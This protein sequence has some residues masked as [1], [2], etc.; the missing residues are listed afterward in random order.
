MRQTAG[1][2]RGCRVE[3]FL[4][5]LQNGIMVFAA[6]HIEAAKRCGQRSI[7]VRKQQQAPRK[8]LVASDGVP[9]HLALAAEKPP[10]NPMIIELKDDRQEESPHRTGQGQNGQNGRIGLAAAEED[11]QTAEQQPQ[12]DQQRPDRIVASRPA[13]PA[14]GGRGRLTGHGVIGNGS[15]GRHRDGSLTTGAEFA[16]IPIRTTG[17]GGIRENS[18]TSGRSVD[19][20]F[21]Y[22]SV[23]SRKTP[24]NLG[25][26]N[27]GF[28]W[29]PIPAAA[30][31]SSPIGSFP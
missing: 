4:H 19:A 27:L 20:L 7:L 8:N 22:S 1:A 12:P 14:N 26:N 17:C 5:Q 30:D 3:V 24:R 16:G 21:Q 28:Q 9:S 11:E 18:A 6:G 13:A 29:Q 2:S 15:F 31:G 25:K 23:F 10:S